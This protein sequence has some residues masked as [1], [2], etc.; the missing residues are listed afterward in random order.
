MMDSLCLNEELEEEE[1][2]SLHMTRKKK[3]AKLEEYSLFT[4]DVELE[5]EYSCYMMMV[6]HMM[7]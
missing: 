3:K 2:F 5:G 4:L 1:E 6:F 7:E